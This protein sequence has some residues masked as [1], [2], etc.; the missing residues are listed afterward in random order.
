ML[1]RW[2]RLE[3]QYVVYKLNDPLKVPFSPHHIMAHNIYMTSLGM[4]AFVTR[5]RQ[6]LPRFT[7]VVTI[8][9]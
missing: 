2:K 8:F 1:A 4:L 6:G 9:C 5:L 7:I 3:Y